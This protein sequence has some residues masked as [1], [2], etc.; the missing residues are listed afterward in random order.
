MLAGWSEFEGQCQA[1]RGRHSCSV[2]LAA[3]Q[4]GGP[5]AVHQVNPEQVRAPVCTHCSP[6]IR[7]ESQGSGGIPA[8]RSPMGP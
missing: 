6:A 3:I 7:E 5:A 4:A 1:S 8:P 2:G